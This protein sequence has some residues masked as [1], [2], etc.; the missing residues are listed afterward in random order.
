MEQF[1]LFDI[2]S[3]CIGVCQANAR[4]YC[5]GCY[6]SR[7][8]RFTW[9]DM[10]DDEKREV[11]RLCKQREARAQNKTGDTTPPEQE[12]AQQQLPFDE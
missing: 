3:P 11:L 12:A 6:R 5:I 9:K 1:E 7:Q 2:K 4:G 10:T 8:E